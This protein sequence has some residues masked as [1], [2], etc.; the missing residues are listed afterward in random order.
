MRLPYD[1]Q[2]EILLC[3][4]RRGYPKTDPI[5]GLLITVAILG[6]VWQSVKAVFTR[7]LDGVEPEVS[8]EVRH[9]AKHVAGV[10][11]VSDVRARWVGHRLRAEV[12]ITV[13]P[14]LSVGDSHDLA[15][16]VELEMRRHLKFLSGVIVHVDPEA[17]AGEQFHTR[18]S[19]E[20]AHAQSAPGHEHAHG[21]LEQSPMIA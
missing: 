8:D 3:N 6:I 2:V 11:G 5:I 15:K 10:L 18:D 13:A 16:R 21:T 20:A 17:E 12:N 7:M 14:D 19:G 1:H 9:S 4:S